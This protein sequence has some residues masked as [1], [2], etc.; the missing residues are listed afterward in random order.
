MEWIKIPIGGVVVKNDDQVVR[1]VIKGRRP[2]VK[3]GEYEFYPRSWRGMARRGG[4]L[5]S[6]EFPM[7]PIKTVCVDSNRWI[8][9]VWR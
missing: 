1:V 3:F 4:E 5:V 7:G 9:V 6:W 2:I 8:Q